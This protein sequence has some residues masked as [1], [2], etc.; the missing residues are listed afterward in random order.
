MD[1]NSKNLV[2]LNEI[3]EPLN[4]KLIKVTE[5]ERN[6]LNVDDYLKF[7]SSY[8][9]LNDLRY[10]ISTDSNC[11]L[12]IQKL[13]IWIELKLLN[14]TNWDF[15]N[16][17]KQNISDGIISKFTANI[18]NTDYIK[19]TI[20]KYYVI[21]YDSNIFEIRFD[22]NHEKTSSGSAPIEYVTTVLSKSVL[23]IENLLNNIKMSQNIV[24]SF[25]Y[26]S[27]SMFGSEGILST[28]LVSNN[29]FPRLL[30][31][32][33]INKFVNNIVEDIKFY[34]KNYE[35]LQGLG[36]SSGLNYLV[37]GPPGNGKTSL[38]INAACNN[39]LDIYV[40]NL[41]SIDKTNLQTALSGK[42]D[43]LETMHYPTNS[44]FQQNT[45]KISK[46]LLIED[47]DRYLDVM[48]TNIKKYNM[49]DILNSLD[50]LQASNNI[51]RIFTANIKERINCQS[52]LS[53]FKRI[54]YIENPSENVIKNIVTG[55]CDIFKIKIVDTDLQNLVSLF[56]TNGMKIRNINKYL[57]R[58]VEF[59]EPLKEAI[60]NFKDFTRE[61][62]LE[63]YSDDNDFTNIYL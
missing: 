43:Y 28:E 22:I 15:F 59:D 27:K 18:M 20:N 32:N 34:E 24:R 60:A 4:I 30:Y 39:N 33:Q 63:N 37:F 6:I 38:S 13:I 51:V 3:F 26:L 9:K 45:C 19:A 23:H 8:C 29:V 62:N 10:L 2:E 12:K 40:L 52:L 31:G 46:I 5:S 48:D 41:D 36:I 58:F 14:N 55:I 35:M 42:C 49:S 44:H 50:G 1:N 56:S 25:R 61:N 11:Y 16:I 21:E 54:F 17:C 57:I 47:F 7:I 53:R